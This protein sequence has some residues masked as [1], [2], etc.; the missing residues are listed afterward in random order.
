MTSIDRAIETL[1][2][3]A[4]YLLPYNVPRGDMES[5][6]LITPLKRSVIEIDG[7][8]VGVFFNRADHGEYYL[9][10]LQI[11]GETIPFLPFNLV[12]KIARRFLGN[13]ITYIDIG[14]KDR[15]YYCWACHIDK[16]GRPIKLTF[17]MSPETRCYEDFEYSYIKTDGLNIY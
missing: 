15:K 9:E 4:D 13:D 12:L 2:N 10:A 3:A 16:R 11:Y 17:N 7:Y 5:E 8:T 1:R 14:N 6:S